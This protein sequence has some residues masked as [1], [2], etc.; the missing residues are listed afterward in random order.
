MS[1]ALPIGVVIPTLNAMDHMAEHLDAVRAWAPR[2]EEIVLVDS[3]SEDGTPEYVRANLEHSN[4]RVLSHPPG[5]YAS[6]NHGIGNV[7]SRYTYI[8]TIGDTMTEA[9]LEHLCAVAEEHEA[10]VVVSPP[11]FRQAEGAELV[12][13]WWPVHDMLPW[14]GIDEPT[15]LD[16][17]DAFWFA[18]H[19]RGSILGSSASDL[20]RTAHLV[21]RPFPTDCGPVGDTAWGVINALGS[22]IVLTPERVS[23]FLFHV[24]E[25]AD[26]R[27][28]ERFGAR[29]RK[30]VDTVL[31]DTA[32]C[33]VLD[34]EPPE[35]GTAA[36]ES[37]ADHLRSF[38][39]AHALKAEGARVRDSSGPLWFLKPR[40]RRG[41]AQRNEQRVRLKELLHEMEAICRRALP[42][43]VRER[44]E[45]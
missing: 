41:L 22:R 3:H 33:A 18:L 19:Y 43:R 27:A 29:R 7:T 45:A 26:E 5:L 31:A 20:Y 30:S 6:W 15:R 42:A 2:V 25:G 35:R 34:G 16:P 9:G 36:V 11:T 37:I 1:A 8:S 23:T 17:V 21:D 32:A 14:L 13:E 12:D 40:A 39:E 10:D 4:L 28:L 38:G 44:V 24:R